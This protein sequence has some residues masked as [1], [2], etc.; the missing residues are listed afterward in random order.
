MGKI[1][2]ID[3]WRIA[4]TS[5]SEKY[6][7][8]FESI[9]TLGNG[10]L[11]L[12]NTHEEVYPTE[13]RN[14]F[15]AGIFNRFSPEETTELANFPDISKIEISID[16]QRFS[17]LSGETTN[18]KREFNY[19]NGEAIR[20][21]DWKQE[22]YAFH[23]T[24]RKFASMS[25]KH[26]IVHEIKIKNLGKDAR[27]TF[28]TGIDG[29]YTNSG[30]QN[31]LENERRF[32]DNKYL[33]LTTKTTQSKVSVSLACYTH[34]DVPHVSIPQMGRRKI[35]EKKQV[36]LK[37]DQS[38][39]L[40]KQS[41]I[42]TQR[43][44]KYSGKDYLQT[45]LL[46]ELSQIADQSYEILQKESAKAW[47]DIW[48]QGEIE[49]DSEDVKDNLLLNFARYHL[50]AMS[51]IHDD[52]LNIGAKGMTGEGYK[53]HTFWDTE[54]FILPYFTY[55]Y[56]EFAKS[57]VRY[58]INGLAAAKAN[59]KRNNYRGA[60]YPW[61]SAWLSDGEATPKLGGVDIVTGKQSPILTGLIEHHVTG[62]VVYG[63]LQCIEATQDPKLKVDFFEVIMEAARFWASRSV[64]NKIKDRYEILDVIGP[65]EY[66]EHVDN[67]AYTNY[68]AKFTIDEAL[69]AYYANDENSFKVQY[70]ADINWLT[71]VSE[72]LYLP[73][74]NSANVIPQDDTFLKK[75]MIDLSK[76][77]ESNSIGT[78]GL[79][80]N[81]EQISNLQVCKQADVILLLQLF[82]EKFDYQTKLANWDYY[83]PKTLHDSSLSLT[84]HCNFALITNQIDLAYKMFKKTFDIDLGDRNMNSSDDGIH[85]ASLG[86]IWQNVVRG[87]GGFTV[88]DFHVTIT[89]KL[90]KQWRSL[91][92]TVS[93]FNATIK[94]DITKT[95]IKTT[96]KK[97]T[98]SDIV[99]NG[100]TLNFDKEALSVEV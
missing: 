94:V 91:S 18:Y 70:Q 49:I 67:N 95:T 93:V 9:M 39:C 14:M 66:T 57:L 77:F 45:E 92:Y 43:D 10:Y 23:F 20:S 84:S 30:T 81:M 24:F 25:N 46:T 55:T 61:E 56:P 33:Y 19:Q 15:V 100:K 28:E 99:I 97:G 27:I 36:E 3:K 96:L 5:F 22:E 82:P 11:T 17:L 40:T 71:E 62:D 74:P 88:Q 58:R 86:G 47:Q 8:K 80:Y 31:F 90:P 72:K 44:V 38:V 12:R 4:E 73:I 42:K 63:G 34:L 6:L 35:I 53:G 65:D 98:L 76:Y 64:Y 89:P 21:F 68:L 78:I 7:A 69:R 32:F 83:Y 26:L 48:D 50:H 60:Q 75:E 51:P 16:G 29:T 87:F 85:S 37:S 2:Y 79:D 52:R 54:I 59:A 1:A 41:L 13:H